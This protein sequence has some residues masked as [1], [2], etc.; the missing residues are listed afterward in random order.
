MVFSKTIGEI[1]D[2]NFVYARALYY[3]GIS[4]FENQ[5]KSLEQVCSEQG[6]NKGKV[7]QNFYDFD[8]CTRISFKELKKYPI[9]ILLAYL[10]H[11]HHL[12]IKDN[13]PFIIYLAKNCEILEMQELLPELMEGFIAHIYE[14]EDTIFKYVYTLDQIYKGEVSNPIA[15]LIMYRNFSLY[16]KYSHHQEEDEMKAI[17]LLVESVKP[18]NL[19]ER[20]LIKEVKA[21]DRE[22]LYHA[23]IENKIFFPKALSLEQ[24]V[25]DQLEQTSFLN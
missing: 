10:K 23:E 6:L 16:Q 14:E 17:R 5:S 1:I 2:E 8:G 4:F 15:K 19:R 25:F 7:I 18:R 24:T 22:M 11:A 13:L 3:L 20:V 21:L 12:F 9:D